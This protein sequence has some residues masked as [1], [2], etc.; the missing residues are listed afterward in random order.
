MP[1]ILLFRSYLDQRSIFIDVFE[2]SCLQAC[3]IESAFVLNFL[4][5]QPTPGLIIIQF[6]A[7]WY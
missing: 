6:S 1:I 4:C 3:L 7:Q 5:I 2:S